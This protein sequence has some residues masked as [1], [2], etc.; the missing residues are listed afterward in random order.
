MTPG[1]CLRLVRPLRRCTRRDCDETGGQH[2]ANVD[3][4]DITL[5]DGT[6][7]V[8]DESGYLTALGPFA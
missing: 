8:T 1:S 5:G 7:Y 4:A 6:N 2:E 3:V